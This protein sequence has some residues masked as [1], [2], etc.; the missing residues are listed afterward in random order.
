V[1]L[2]QNENGFNGGS[3]LIFTASA[4]TTPRGDRLHFDKVTDKGRRQSDALPPQVQ[5][6]SATLWEE[7]FWI[8]WG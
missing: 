3:G 2:T 6:W 5:L 7:R 4:R 8:D 1:P